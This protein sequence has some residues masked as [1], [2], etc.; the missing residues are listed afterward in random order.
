VSGFQFGLVNVATE[1]AGL[2]FGIINWDEDGIGFPLV[3]W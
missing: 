3:N 1:D 2:Q